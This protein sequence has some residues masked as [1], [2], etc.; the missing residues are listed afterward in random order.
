MSPGQFLAAMTGSFA[1]LAR[2]W[3][4]PAISRILTSFLLY[5]TA[6]SMLHVVFVEFG[7]DILMISPMERGLIFMFI[8]IVGAV[9]QFTAIKPMVSR[10]GEDRTIEIGMATMAVGLGIMPYM[11]TYALVF[12]G[13]FFISAGNSLVTPVV[14]A[15]ISQRSSDSEQ[16]VAMG[17]TQSLGSLGRI[18]GPPYG[19]MSY[20]LLGYRFP[21]L[22]GAVVAIVALL[23]YAGRARE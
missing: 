7:R 16:G 20:A 5:T 17:V 4:R 3:R 18:I 21:F 1:N 23:I 8:G 11:D 9:I 2:F 6:F 15:V 22:S 10:W 13:S 19:G 12:I 14:S